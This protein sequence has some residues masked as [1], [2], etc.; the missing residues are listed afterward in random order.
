[1][2]GPLWV[3]CCCENY[4]CMR[5]AKHAFECP[6]PHREEMDFDPYTE[7]KPSGAVA[8]PGVQ[9]DAGGGAL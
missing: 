6:C 3:L 1:M 5:H 2:D 4:F 7:N 8:G 9:L